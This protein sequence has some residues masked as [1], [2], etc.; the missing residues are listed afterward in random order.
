MCVYVCQVVVGATI[1]NYMLY[2]ILN[3]FKFELCLFVLKPE[4]VLFNVYWFYFYFSFIYNFFFFTFNK[5]N[6]NKNNSVFCNNL[7]INSSHWSQR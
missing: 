4:F 5:N 3:F 7:C 1:L 2:Y 6:K